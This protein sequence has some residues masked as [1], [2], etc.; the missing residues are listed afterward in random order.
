MIPP[1]VSPP[2]T[3]AAITPKSGTPEAKLNVPSIGSTTMAV[4]ASASF[5][6]SAGSAATDSSPTNSTPGNCAATSFLMKRSAASSAS[7]TRSL[8]SALVRMSLLAS[9]RKRGRISASAACASTSARALMSIVVI[10]VLPFPGR[11]NRK[12]LGQ[13][14]GTDW[15]G[16]ER[17]AWCPCGPACASRYRPA[18]PSSRCAGGR[19]ASR[20]GRRG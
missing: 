10:R 18:S 4:S 8:A 2:E 14:D 13:E 19:P 11:R 7:V 3:I 20:R 16:R 5:D 9:A 12:V 17:A 15:C 6:S 1:T